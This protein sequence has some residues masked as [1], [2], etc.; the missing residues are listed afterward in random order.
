MNPFRR[1]TRLICKLH[2]SRS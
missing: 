1:T 2:L